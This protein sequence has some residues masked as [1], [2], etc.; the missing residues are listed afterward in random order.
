MKFAIRKMILLLLAA[1]LLASGC[2]VVRP[3]VALD[4]RDLTQVVMQKDELPENYDTYS[5]ENF[6]DLFPKITEVQTGVVN[7]TVSLLRSSDNRHVFSNGIAVYSTEEQAKAAYKAI[8][9]G[10]SGKQIDSVKDLGDENFVMYDTIESDLITNQ[11]FLEMI[12][13]RYGKSVVYLSSA[14]SDA[15]PDY[16]NMVALAQKI[17]GRLAGE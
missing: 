6:A 8:I 10:T 3:K 13:W 17:H 11:I 4:K 12:L 15:R 2:S 16:D 7:S 9:D 14:D 5:L 1:A